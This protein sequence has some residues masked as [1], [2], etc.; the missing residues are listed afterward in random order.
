MDYELM[1]K[2]LFIAVVF[3]WSG[4]QFRASRMEKQILAVN[5][6][7]ELIIRDIQDSINQE[8][9]FSRIERDGIMKQQSE[10]LASL[11]AYNK[12]YLMLQKQEKKEEQAQKQEASKEAQSKLD[13]LKQNKNGGIKK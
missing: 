10:V 6:K 1:A 9:Q 5:E 2:M 11:E 4:W 7:F 8:L 13:A 12:R 3:F